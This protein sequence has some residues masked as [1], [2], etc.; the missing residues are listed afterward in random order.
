MTHSDL[1]IEDVRRYWDE[2]PVAASSVSHVPGTPAFFDDCDRL[3]E[4]A[5]PAG[6]SRLL[7]EY[8]DF[9]GER[10]LDVG[11]GN[12][13]VLSRYADP[14]DLTPAA[15]TLSRRRF[16]LARLE[17]T[18][19]VANAEALPFEDR[20]SDCVCSMGVLHH[21]PNTATA[22]AE[23]H[24]VL[25]L[26][27]RLIVMF[28]DR[29]SALYQVRSWLEHLVRRTP[30]AQLVNEVDGVG[31]PKGDVYSR[32]ELRELVCGFEGIEMLVS[33]IQP[34]MVAPKVSRYIP[35]RLLDPFSS[36]FGWFLYAKARK[37]AS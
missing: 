35:Q 11:C 12:G 2:H 1:T 22:V 23:I 16:E 27:G 21:V 8:A 19:Q 17:G 25:R 37:H 29:N 32:S 4:T 30:M 24:R 36:R 33:L 5:E 26:G 6:Y 20:T 34:W 3:R 9:S 7:H 10:M 13:C 18:F 14:V 28:Y 31:N 15:I